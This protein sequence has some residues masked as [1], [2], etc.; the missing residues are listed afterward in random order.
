MIFFGVCLI[1]KL[2]KD[3]L[4]RPKLPTPDNR[5]NLLTLIEA[6]PNRA[7][8]EISISMATMHQPTRSESA[9][10]VAVEVNEQ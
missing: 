2:E 9:S 3:S 4:Y 7:T 8:P 10:D 6:T 5:P 1:C